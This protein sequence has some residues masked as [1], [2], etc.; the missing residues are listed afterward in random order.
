MSR[1]GG[2]GCCECFSLLL[3]LGLS[4]LF[5]WLAIRPKGPTIS[6]TALHMPALNRTAGEGGRNGTARND[7]IAMDIKLENTNKDSGI[8]YDGLNVSLWFNGSRL[9]GESP[10]P[11]FYQGK[12]KTAHKQAVFNGTGD[13]WEAVLREGSNASQ[14]VFRVVLKTWVR[15]KVVWWNTGH[16]SGEYV[17]NVPVGTDGERVGKN[18]V[19]LK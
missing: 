6:V 7:T 9:V 10:L 3:L 16:H 4:A 18:G 2:C 5:T 19:R 8:H 17:G 15:Y 11:A 13:G 14:V 12:K 1:G